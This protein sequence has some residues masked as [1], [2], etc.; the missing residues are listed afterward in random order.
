M[1]NKIYNKINFHQHTFCVFTE[2]SFNEIDN[3]KVDYKSKSGSRYYFSE[4]G[5]HRLS[6]HW[7]RAAKCKWRLEGAKGDKGN[8]E[9]L[10]FSL[11]AGFQADND[12][13]KLYFIT[14][15]FN[16]KTTNYQ[17]KNNEAYSDKD[18]LRTV[19]DSTKIIK[20]IRNLF[21][22][23]SWAKYFDSGDVDYLRN[24]IIEEL[25]STNKSLQEIKSEILNK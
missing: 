5:V 3:R 17:H 23:D 7:G 19:A 24:K 10:G 6:D 21:A 25:I 18:I 4:N 9:R 13:E 11:W 15:D 14:A 8:R 20:Q 1:K 16:F 2:V 22:S 12:T